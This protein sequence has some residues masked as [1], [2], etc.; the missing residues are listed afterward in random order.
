MLLP[1]LSK[2]ARTCA[3]Q[4]EGAPHPPRHT[5]NRP[6]P[7]AHL[8]ATRRR[9]MQAPVVLVHHAA[10]PPAAAVPVVGVVVGYARG[11]IA[12]R[13]IH[14][15][16]ANPGTKPHTNTVQEVQPAQG[17]LSPR[18]RQQFYPWAAPW[19]KRSILAPRPTTPHST[20][21]HQTKQLPTTKPGSIPPQ[22]HTR[23]TTPPTVGHNARPTAHS[24]VKRPQHHTLSVP[25]LH[26]TNALHNHT[27]SAPLTAPHH[28]PHCSATT[29]HKPQADGA[30]YPSRTNSSRANSK[31]RGYGNPYRTSPR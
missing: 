23:T 18:L 5:T 9:C 13:V 15:V 6:S 1:G 29:H 16:S 20:D 22:P 28:T 25:T 8:V 14:Y 24:Q 11:L 17:M 10:R 30:T 31:A 21:P 7:P 19:V 26:P 27:T 4:M 2:P 3:C 12:R